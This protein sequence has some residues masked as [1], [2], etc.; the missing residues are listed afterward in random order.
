[1]DAVKAQLKNGLLRLARDTQR[2]KSI[3]EWPW[4][5]KLNLKAN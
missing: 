5:I 3:T 4:V 1:M 2:V